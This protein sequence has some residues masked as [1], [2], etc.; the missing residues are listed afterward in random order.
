MSKTVTVN[1]ARDA[2]DES[3]E[4]FFVNLSNPTNASIKELSGT[5]SDGQGVGTILDDDGAAPPPPPPPSKPTLRIS[6]ARIREGSKTG[7]TLVRLTV[8]LSSAS[9]KVVKV[10]F[11]TANG[12]AAGS[13]KAALT[14]DYVPVSATAPSSLLTFAVGQTS[15]T[16]TLK[17]RKDAR[18]EPAERFFVTLSGAVNATLVAFDNTTGDL[19]GIVTILNDD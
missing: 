10:R 18:K 16:I 17:V 6:D 4:R 19:R 1:V 9:D 12:T 13:V 7:F 5:P 3:N 8:S 2:V 14:T 11:G 15:K